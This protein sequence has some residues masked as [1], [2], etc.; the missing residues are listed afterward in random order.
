MLSRLLYYLGNSGVF[1]YA[2][3]PHSFCCLSGSGKAKW[4]DFLTVSGLKTAP[5][6]NTL[7]LELLKI[8]RDILT[9]PQNVGVAVAVGAAIGSMLFGWRLYQDQGQRCFEEKTALWNE[10]RRQDSVYNADRLKRVETIVELRGKVAECQLTAQRL[11]LK[12]ESLEKK[13]R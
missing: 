5:M 6:L 7:T 2:Y 9:K 11:E 10:L 12:I 3:L 1:G 4:H 13:R 8:A